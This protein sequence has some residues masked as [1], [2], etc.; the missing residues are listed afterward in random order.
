MNR[1]KVFLF[2]LLLTILCC[3][4]NQSYDSDIITAAESD[5]YL[6]IYSLDKAYFLDESIDDGAAECKDTIKELL[7]ATTRNN[8]PNIDHNIDTLLTY[9]DGQYLFEKYNQ[10]MT[11]AYST[12]SQGAAVVSF[13]FI[14]DYATYMINILYCHYDLQNPQNQGIY[15]I[16]VVDVPNG[17][18]QELSWDLRNFDDIEPSITCWGISSPDECPI[19]H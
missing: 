14:T 7:S 18:H 11:Y 15:A 8:V 9:I 19:K 2:L 17:V 13:Y 4:C 1:L 5:G 10:S 3:G 6:L 12:E 16:Y